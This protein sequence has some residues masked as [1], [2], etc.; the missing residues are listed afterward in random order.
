MGKPVFR[1]SPGCEIACLACDIRC[2][3]LAGEADDAWRAV[4]DLRRRQALRPAPEQAAILKRAEVLLA[5]A[6]RD[7]VRARPGGSAELRFPAWSRTSA[8]TRLH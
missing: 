3:I 8:S 2:A 6:E 5:G 1:A 4:E 7:F